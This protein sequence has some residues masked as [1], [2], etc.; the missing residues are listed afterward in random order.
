MTAPSSAPVGQNV[1]V[2]KVLIAVAAAVFAVVYVGMFLG[3]LP[4]LKLDRSGIALLGAI[5]VIP[6][7]GSSVED[8]ARAVASQG[9]VDAGQG[10]GQFGVPGA[11][12]EHAGAQH[13]AGEA[14]RGG[15]GEGGLGAAEDAALGAGRSGGGGH[16]VRSSMRLWRFATIGVATS[17]S[18]ARKIWRSSSRPMV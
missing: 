7:I 10:P 15:G 12:G 2:R 16:S 18:S 8:A 13:Q 11:D 14:P 4:T 3:G 5:A 1:R 17:I 9:E 6:L